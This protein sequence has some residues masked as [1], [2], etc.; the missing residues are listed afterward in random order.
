MG[1]FSVKIH[2]ISKLI[3]IKKLINIQI[4]KKAKDILFD[5]YWTSKGWA[6]ER[7]QTRSIEAFDYAKKHGLMFDDLTISHDEC[8]KELSLLLPNLSK[9]KVTDAFLSSL[10][11]RRLDWRSALGSYANAAKFIN[12]NF[13]QSPTSNQCQ[14]CG[15]YEKNDDSDINVLNFE[16][17]KWGGVRHGQILYN[18]IDLQ[19]LMTLDIPEPSEKDYS[20]F[21]DLLEIIKAS[22]DA[23]KPNDLEKSIKNAFSSNKSERHQLLEIL[24]CTDILKPQIQKQQKNEWNF[25]CWWR[26]KDKYNLKQLKFY[27]GQYAEIHF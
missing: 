22:Q 16:R 23:D 26:G 27:F 4:D 19:I 21:N 13:T 18:L 1:Y 25:I 5:T 14:I 15:C 20:I 10:S 6:D 17:I 2:A 3:L 11:A 9:K 24:G 8:L 12:H 7:P